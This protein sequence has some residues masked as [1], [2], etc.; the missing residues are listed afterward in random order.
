MKRHSNAGS[1]EIAESPTLKQAVV[2]TDEMVEACY[3]HPERIPLPGKRLMKETLERALR[4]ANLLVIDLPYL[5]V[6]ARLAGDYMMKAK[7]HLGLRW[8]GALD[9]ALN[10]IDYVKVALDPYVS[11]KPAEPPPDYKEL[12]TQAMHHLQIVSGS[13]NSLSSDATERLFDL[14]QPHISLRTP[15][16]EAMHREAAA[17][18]REHEYLIPKDQSD[19]KED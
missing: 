17:W 7:D 13:R 2:V 8:I 4:H 19:D 14:D 9:D 3:T 12:F 18:L 5:H 6:H 15:Q 1:N 10:H 16:V 11:S